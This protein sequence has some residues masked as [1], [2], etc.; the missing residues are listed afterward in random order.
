MAGPSKI[1]VM[2]IYTVHFRRHGLDL[3]RDVVLVREGFSWA[4]FFLNVLWAAWQ[5]MWLATI[6]ILVVSVVLNAINWGLGT[7]GTTSF[8][9]A[10]GM[11]ALLGLFA[12]DLK[13]WTLERQG[14]AE[15]GVVVGDTED[16][17]LARFLE[18]NPDLTRGLV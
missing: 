14:F 17:A 8:I 13:R 7:D 5:R 18:E 11:A 16:Q 9:L 2:K 12:H 10:T 6:G 4:A 3:D 1:Y 15:F